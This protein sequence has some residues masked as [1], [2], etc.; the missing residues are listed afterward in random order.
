MSIGNHAGVNINIA[1]VLLRTAVLENSGRQERGRWTEAIVRDEV[2]RPAD[3][4]EV[5]LKDWE[6]REDKTRIRQLKV[7]LQPRGQA[8][9][10]LLKIR[11][12]KQNSCLL[13]YILE[14]NAFEKRVLAPAVES[15]LSSNIFLPDTR[16]LLLY[17]HAH[18]PWYRLR[19][20]LYIY[21]FL[22]TLVYLKGDPAP[23]SKSQKG[24]ASN[25]IARWGGKS[26]SV[27]GQ[28]R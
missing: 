12:P 20:C 25:A 27:R 6:L 26:G 18:L 11:S 9:V 22:A 3:I 2:A 16:L 8:P 7:G 17:G 4:S 14:M 28:H 5:F 19:S 15:H 1:T 23:P 13:Q 21:Y 24:G 10:L